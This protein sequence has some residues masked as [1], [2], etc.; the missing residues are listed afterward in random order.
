MQPLTKLMENGLEYTGV[1]NKK[2]I[3]QPLGM[4]EDQ[5][6]DVMNIPIV[7]QEK[8]LTADM[9]AVIVCLIQITLLK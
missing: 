9:M 8:S 5:I 6:L 4:E 7:P 3:T 2:Y 1:H